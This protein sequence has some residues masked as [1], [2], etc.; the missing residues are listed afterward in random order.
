MLAPVSNFPKATLLI[1]IRENLQVSCAIVT[2]CDPVKAREQLLPKFG[3]SEARYKGHALKCT[4]LFRKKCRAVE[5]AG[6][7]V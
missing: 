5:E 4:V 2:G 3:G 7:V 1:K 6:T